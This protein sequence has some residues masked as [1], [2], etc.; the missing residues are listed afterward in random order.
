MLP[1]VRLKPLISLISLIPLMTVFVLVLSFVLIFGGRLS[2][3]GFDANLILIGNALL[4]CIST[5]SFYIHSKALTTPNNNVFFRYVYGA[6][7][8]KFAMGIL[9]ILL[10]ILISGHGLN[11]YGLFFC[12]FLYF[13]Y[14][15]IELKT[16]MKQIKQNK[17]A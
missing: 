13:V 16:L 10:Y 3:W 8:G 7:V 14:S 12:L 6:F 9:L 2:H 15:F 5:L 4:F 17:N 1:K 11:K